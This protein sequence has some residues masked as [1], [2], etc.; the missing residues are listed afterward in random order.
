MNLNLKLYMNLN[1]ILLKYISFYV[2]AIINKTAVLKFNYD[3]SIT[4]PST[5]YNSPLFT[6][7]RWIY[8]FIYQL[9]LNHLKL[10]ILMK[11]INKH[12]LKLKKLNNMN[13]HLGNLQSGHFDNVSG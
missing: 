10:H 4:H 6:G 7:L 2:G 5:S 8:H 9:L 1:I 11:M 3:L 12:L 13:N